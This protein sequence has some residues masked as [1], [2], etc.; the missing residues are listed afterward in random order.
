VRPRRQACASV[1]PFNFT[2]RP[3]MRRSLAA[4]TLLLG[5]LT[6]AGCRSDT[7]QTGT[8]RLSA[9][10]A[11]QIAIA[12]RPDSMRDLSKYDPPSA[13]FQSAGRTWLVYFHDKAIAIDGCFYLQVDDR[14][15][16]LSNHIL[17]C[18]YRRS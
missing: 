10:D 17:P 15:G 6:I 14:T 7:F 12:H 16:S 8:P 18:A 13:S 3:H 4:A 11:I 5:M 1:R 2:V 9:S